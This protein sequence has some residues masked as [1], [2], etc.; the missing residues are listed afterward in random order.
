MAFKEGKF[1]FFLGGKQEELQMNLSFLKKIYSL[2]K[3]ESLGFMKLRVGDGRN[4]HSWGNMEGSRKCP[5]PL[6]SN[7]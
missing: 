4:H 5:Q 1:P 3:D 2:S 6:R 7:A